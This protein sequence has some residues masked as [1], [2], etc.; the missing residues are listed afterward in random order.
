MT[1][2]VAACT[3]LDC[4]LYNTVYTVYKIQKAN[5]KAD[6]L[7]DT[8]SVW[9]TR[10]DNSDTVIINKDVNIT[11]FELPV[12]YTH[13][14]DLFVFRISDSTS[15]TYDTIRVKKTDTPHFESTDCSPSYF[16]TLTG[17]DC[18]H[19]RIDSIIINN[20]N[21]TYDATKEHFH[22]FFKSGN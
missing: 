12:S 2:F 14:E 1:L 16:H 15:V 9:T 3:T 18:T 17:I 21:V 22:I 20:S 10:I 4:P 7:K 13:P 11:S 8:I 6:T 5:G 19:N